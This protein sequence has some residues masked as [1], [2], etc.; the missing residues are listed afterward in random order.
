M[1][2]FESKNVIIT[3]SAEG[4]G[5]EIALGFCKEG[6]NIILVDKIEPTETLSLIQQQGG[7]ATYLICDITDEQQVINMAQEA[8]KLFNGTID[9]LIN[10]AGFNGRANLIKDMKLSDWQYTLNVNLT[11]SMLVCREIIPFMIQKNSGCIVNMASNV[12]KRGLPYRGDYVCS[13][14]AIRGLTQTLALELAD[15]NI[16]V[17]AVCP[18]PIEGE[19]IKQLLEMHSKAEGI[20]YEEMYES[21][22]NVP[23]KKMISPQEVSDVVRFLCASESSAMTGQSLNITGGMLMD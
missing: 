11:G 4:V 2:R 1:K 9:I 10:N 21:W 14:W 16:R 17:N 6:A 20:P 19:R 22:K 12:G 7:M 18:G 3:G 23:L 15:Y 13:K 8:G 5:R